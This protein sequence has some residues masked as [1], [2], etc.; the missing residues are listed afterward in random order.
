MVYDYQRP[1]R[2]KPLIHNGLRQLRNVYKKTRPQGPGT[3]NT[4][5]HLVSGECLYSSE[6]VLF[7]LKVSGPK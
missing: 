3:L 1:R 5:S 2:H 4:G 6:R 7:F